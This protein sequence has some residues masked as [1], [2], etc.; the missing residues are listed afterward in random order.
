MKRGRKMEFMI[1]FLVGF[2]FVSALLQGVIKS[3]KARK[4][5]TYASSAA[6]I[7]AALMFTVTYYV[8][9]GEAMTF[10]ESA[11]SGSLPILATHVLRSFFYQTYWSSTISALELVIHLDNSCVME[12]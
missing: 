3:N 5:I 1:A 7:L 12:V 8:Y 10:N 6:L 9:G 2:P 4:I 11:L